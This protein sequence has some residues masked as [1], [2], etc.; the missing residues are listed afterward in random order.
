MLKKSDAIIL[1]TISTTP[2]SAWKV[3]GAVGGVDKWF[4]PLIQSC[5]VE[6]NKRF[7]NTEAGILNEDIL[8]VDHQNRVFRYA[9]PEQ[10]LIPVDNILG[11]IRVLE[12]EN[13]KTAIEW[14]AAFDVLPEREAEAKE[15]FIGAWTMGIEGLERYINSSN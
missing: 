4:A 11:K 13:N 3:I 5:R 15:M 7:C 6:G 12:V 8:E 14:S 10:K 9:I 2:E 1:K